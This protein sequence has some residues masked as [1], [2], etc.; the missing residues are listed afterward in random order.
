MTTYST[1]YPTEAFGTITLASDGANIVGLWLP[2]QKY[3]AGTVNDAMIPDATLPVFAK[4]CAW[5]DRY[6]AG[7]R[8]AIAEVSLAPQGSAFRQRVWEKLMQIPYGQTRTYGDIAAELASEDGVAKVAAQA[9]G[10]AVGHNPISIII[11]C[12]RVVGAR[13]SLTGYAGGIDK[14]VRLLA[15]EGVNM[16][17]LF[18]PKTGTAL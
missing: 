2:G 15:H 9:V 4:A 3:F 5:L 16:D 11:P 12:H 1:T 14:K 10:G 8:P 17:G 7:G 6:F 18:V 13:G